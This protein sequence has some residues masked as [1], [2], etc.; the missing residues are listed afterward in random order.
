[1]LYQFYTFILGSGTLPLAPLLY[2]YL[3]FSISLFF[4]CLIPNF[5]LLFLLLLLILK[6]CFLSFF[7]SGFFPLALAVVDSETGDN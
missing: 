4:Y 1:M 7:R 3:N 5:V 6:F 2:S